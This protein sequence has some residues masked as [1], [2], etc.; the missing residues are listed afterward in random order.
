LAKDKPV[1]DLDSA[2]LAKKTKNF[3]GADLK[4]IFDAAAEKAL[5]DAMKQGRIVPITTKSLIGA[6][7]AIKPSTREWFESAKNYAMYSNQ[8]G[9]YD[10]VLH[11]LGIKK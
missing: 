9:F 4:A 1:S 2:A 10:D 3:S 8:G 7:K 11:F 6:A 5:T